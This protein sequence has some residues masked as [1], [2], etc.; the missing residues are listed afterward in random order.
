MDISQE[1][2]LRRRGSLR[3]QQL[4]HITLA[5][6]L[7]IGGTAAQTTPSREAA[8]IDQ[9]ATEELHRQ[10][11]PAMTVAVAVDGQLIYSKGVGTA[12]LFFPRIHL[13]RKQGENTCSRWR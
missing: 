11:I 13:Q 10:H 3:T 4:A 2:S 8:A 1:R 6:Y 9:I 5:I 12:D 7:T